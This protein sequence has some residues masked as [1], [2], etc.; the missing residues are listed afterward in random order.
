MPISTDLSRAPYFD[1]YDEKDN[2]HRILFKPSVAVQVRELNQLQTILQN[3]VER[4]GD[5]IYKRGTIIDGCN[6]TFHSNLQYVKINDSQTDGA[7]VNVSSFKGL[8]AKNSNNVIAQIVETSTGF[9]STAPNLNTLHLKYL[10][11]GTDGS[12]AFKTEQV[13]TIYNPSLI[14]SEADVEVKSS[15]FS[16]TDNLIIMSAVEVSNTIGGDTFVNATGQACTFVVG[17]TITQDI[18]GAQAQIMEVNSTAN[19][20]TLILKIRP[21]AS[22]LRLAN[23]VSWLFAENYQF[24]SSQSNITGVLQRNIGKDAFGTIVTDSSGGVKSVAILNGGTGY[25]IEPWL[26]VS[27][28]TPNTSTSAEGLINN[29]LISSKNYLCNVQ[30]NEDTASVGS[31]VGIAV[32]EGIIYQKGHFVRVSDQFLVVDKYNA[33]TNNVVGFDTLEEIVNFR[34]D[35]NLL[36]N[37]SGTLNE[38]APGADRL[39]LTPTIAVVNT[40]TAA[41]N[42]DFL[43]LL[44]FQDGYVVKDN[45]DT[46]FNSID[47]ELARRTYDESGNY[48][49]DTSPLDTEDI[50]GN[51]TFFNLLVGGGT[52]Y[53]EG[54][55]VKLENFIKECFNFLI[56]KKEFLEK[57][58]LLVFDDVVFINQANNVK[59]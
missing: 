36:D 20:E 33:Q 8:F 51:T 18:T 5:N 32:S 30:I 55:R 58:H 2:Y 9:E 27:Y 49:I 54:H 26:T 16:N 35:Q 45:T 43:T 23:A 34:V 39:K 17:E 10:T 12:P 6:L 41:A 37:A 57:I 44:E 15:G 13:L 50:S 14:V 3:Q 11:S 31:G 42:T 25:Y 1:D 19:V 40:A 48:V 7:P 38:R 29:L 56:R 47:R 22:N 53:I 21:L 59:F 4:F 24:T 46:K 52:A 28:A